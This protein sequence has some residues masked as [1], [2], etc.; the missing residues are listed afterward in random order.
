VTG[1]QRKDPEVAERW[2]HQGDPIPRVA[3]ECSVG[4]E[5]QQEMD[6]VRGLQRPQ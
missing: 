2:P 4:Q 6:D 5:G 1:H 3:S